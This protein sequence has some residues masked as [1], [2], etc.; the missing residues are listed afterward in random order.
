MR[1][2]FRWKNGRGCRRERDRDLGGDLLVNEDVGWIRMLGITGRDWLAHA[3]PVWSRRS[4]SKELRWP[5]LAL[6]S[7]E[8]SYRSPAADRGNAPILWSREWLRTEIGEW[9]QLTNDARW[10]FRKRPCG[11]RDRRRSTKSE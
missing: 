4:D 1:P 5:T 8:A 11:S 10:S 2:T 3:D 9:A 7:C 6:A